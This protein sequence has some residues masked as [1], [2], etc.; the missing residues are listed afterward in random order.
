MKES[1]LEEFSISTWWVLVAS[2]G[3]PAE[4]IEKL[5]AAFTNGMQT[6]EVQERFGNLLVT[7]M[8]TTAQEFDELMSEDRKSTRLYSS[9]V[10][11]SYADFCL[12]K[13]ITDTTTYNKITT[14]YH[15]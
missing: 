8:P 6:K 15:N 10:A 13:K 14:T 3:T 5:N 11:I 12:K 4:T 1:G 2:A 7:P 9:H